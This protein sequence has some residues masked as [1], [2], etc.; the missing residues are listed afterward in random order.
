MN[1]HTLQVLEFDKIL[2]ILAERTSSPLGKELAHQSR[3]STDFETVSQ[4]LKEVTELKKFISAGENF[5]LTGLKDIRSSLEKLKI[6]GTIL[7]PREL[8]DIAETLGTARRIKKIFSAKLMADRSATAEK[9]PLLYKL[10]NPL[11]VFKEIEEKI[12]QTVDSSGEIL[13][14]ASRKLSQLRREKERIR[15]KIQE[16]LTAVINSPKNKKIIQEP[17]ITLRDERY[18]IPVKAEERTKIKGIVHETSQSGATVFIE[19]L[20]TVELNNSLRQCGLEEK[21]EIQKILN[22]IC[23]LVRFNLAEISQ[24]LNILAEFD[25]ILAKTRLSLDWKCVEP[26]LNTQGYISLKNGRHPFLIQEKEPRADYQNSK[27]AAKKVIPLNLQIGQDFTTLMITGPNTGGKTVALKTIGILVL[28]TQ[29]GMHIPAGEDSE[30]S[31]FPQIFADIGDEQSIE[32]SLSTFSSHLRNV[33]DVLKEANSQSLVLL[34]EIGVGTDPEEGQALAMAILEELTLRQCR[35]IATTHYGTLKVFAHS[36][37]GMQNAAMEFDRTTLHPTYRLMMGV[38][39][40]SYALEIAQR[41]GIPIDVLEKAK[42]FVSSE[43]IHLDE[44]IAKLEESIQEGEKTRWEVNQ[45]S[46]ELTTLISQYE[47]RMETIREEEKRIKERAKEEGRKILEETKRVSQRAIE[48][49]KK[50]PPSHPTVRKIERVLSEEIR[51]LVNSEKLKVPKKP[52]KDLKIGEKLW[53]ESVKRE[54]VLLT[55]PNSQGKVKVQI[56]SLRLDLSA[57]EL[58]RQ[59]VRPRAFSPQIFQRPLEK[60]EEDELETSSVNYENEGSFSPELHLIGKR[61]KESVEI[62]DKYL[63][64]AQ[65]KGISFIKIVHGKGKGILRAVVK[66]ALAKDERVK[67]FRLGEWNEGGSGVTVVEL[68]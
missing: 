47:K 42:G 46:E 38:P 25:L 5:S 24:N 12:E 32:E 52:L 50:Q 28:M 36:K 43:A 65:L 44:L 13:D 23:Q 49:I 48:E 14:K 37:P 39:G 16:K 63:D 18:C 33:K 60:V 7:E 19:P 2:A 62:L 68:K 57:E 4:R 21:R 54:G 20:T 10:T 26:Q 56:G 34:D 67:S 31:L 29:T 17:I 27:V 30:I 6:E 8:L 15:E 9:F 1:D 41:L 58:S 22:E 66:E 61:V 59:S 45:K 35:V 55:L 11:V 3:P 53:L 40:G 51:K 64:D